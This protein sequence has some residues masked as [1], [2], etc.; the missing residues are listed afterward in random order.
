M[1]IFK[2]FFDIFEDFLSQLLKFR[3]NICGQ[4]SFTLTKN[5]TA[6]NIK[7]AEHNFIPSQKILFSK[8]VLK[9]DGS[10]SK[11]VTKC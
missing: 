4:I 10:D 8:N 3:V 11:S 7:S 9:F 5:D 2:T 6:M 1:S